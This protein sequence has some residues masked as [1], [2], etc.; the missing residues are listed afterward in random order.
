MKNR[1]LVTKIEVRQFEYKL[2]DR[3]FR[4]YSLAPVY[5]P[6]S[7]LLGNATAI[8]IFSKAGVTGE[9]VCGRRREA[10]VKNLCIDTSD[11]LHFGRE[12]ENNIEI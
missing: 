6:G 4:K 9:Y 2:P 3:E 7:V 12:I 8:R 10:P 1:P 11:Q 5:K